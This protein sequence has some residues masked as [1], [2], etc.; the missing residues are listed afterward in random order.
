MLGDL[1]GK[2]AEVG[3][4]SGFSLGNDDLMVSHLQLADDTIIFC[5]NSQ[6]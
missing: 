1:L 2:V 5:D 6:R 4:F 3:M